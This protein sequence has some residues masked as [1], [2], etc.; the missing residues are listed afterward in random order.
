MTIPTLPGDDHCHSEWSWDAHA[1]S[2]LGACARAAALG[3]PS[4]AFTEHVDAT[5]WELPDGERDGFPSVGAHDAHGY[6]PPPLDVAGYLDTVAR[7]R[8]RYPQLRI[9]T[10]AELGEP[11]WHRAQVAELLATGAFERVLGSLHSVVVADRI[12]MIDH[13]LGPHA[14]PGFEPADAVRAYLAAAAEMVPA[15]PDEVQVL[16]HIDYPARAWPGRFDAGDFE[17]EFRTVLEALAATGRALEINTRVPLAAEVVGWWRDAGGEAVSF[18]SD[19]HRP[20]SVGHGFR[21]AADL[22]EAHGY[23]PD[24]HPHG[25]W[26]LPAG[27]R[28]H[29]VRRTLDAGRTRGR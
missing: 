7:C 28:R 23:R 1:G 15:L 10:G 12:W 27:V 21:A 19:A 3:L 11:H 5:R 24:R 29:G 18:A 16:G 4:I 14:P 17:P 25:F 13:L 26:H 20:E 9:L 22:A 6:R 2:M 8:A